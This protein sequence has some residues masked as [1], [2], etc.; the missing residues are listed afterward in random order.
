MRTRGGVDPALDFEPHFE[1]DDGCGSPLD[2]PQKFPAFDDLELIE[3]KAMTRRRTEDVI[4]RMGR[5]GEDG[6]KPAG[7]RITVGREQLQFI[8][9]LLIVEQRALGSEDLDEE[10][11][12]FDPT[13]ND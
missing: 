2:S 12:P 6:A 10:F 11:D 4:R 3:T 7:G 1:V 8:E 9:P 13:R 5:P